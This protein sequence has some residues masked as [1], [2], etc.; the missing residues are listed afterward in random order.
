MIWPLVLWAS[1]WSYS[2]KRSPL[3]FYSDR[4]SVRNWQKRCLVSRVSSHWTELPVCNFVGFAIETPGSQTR[5]ERTH[6]KTKENCRFTP[7]KM[8]SC[9]SLRP[10]FPSTQRLCMLQKSLSK[11]GEIG[12]ERWYTL[13][14]LSPSLHID[15]SWSG[16]ANVFWNFWCSLKRGAGTKG[17][18]EHTMTVRVKALQCYVLSRPGD[19]RSA[20]SAVCPGPLL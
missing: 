8:A 2:T 1:G 6:G 7:R 5:S 13:D 16:S 20:V 9:P 4:A 19:T 11:W 17:G 18:E 14:L 15:T 10:K 12:N 3:F